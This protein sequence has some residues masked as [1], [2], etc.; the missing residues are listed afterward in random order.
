MQNEDFI[1]EL[2]DRFSG[3]IRKTSELK[4]NRITVLI[5][6]G[7]L[8]N[9][10]EFLFKEKKFRF[11]IASGLHTREG[12][13][14]L[15]HYSLDTTGHIINLQVILPHENPEID[16]LTKL[17]SAAEWIEREIHELLGI[18]FKGHPNLV[19]LLSKEN[20]PE[21]TYPYRKDFNA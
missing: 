2:N 10:S 8:F 21:G 13:E 17:F 5:D 3:K 20:W 12:F 11:I 19:K 4:Q 18:K 16:S 6:P 15:Y 1:N 9:I 7:S 14:I